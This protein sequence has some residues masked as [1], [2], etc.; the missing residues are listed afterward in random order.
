MAKVCGICNVNTI[1]YVWSTSRY[2]NTNKYLIMKGIH[3]KRETKTF[4]KDGH[5][6]CFGC[7]EKHQLMEK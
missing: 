3:G 1:F 5:T 6:V 4:L 7:V 2:F